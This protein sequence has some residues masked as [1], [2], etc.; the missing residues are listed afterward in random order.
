[1]TFFKN[2]PS[3]SLPK[4]KS[5]QSISTKLPLQLPHLRLH[6]AV[7]YPKGGP[8]KGTIKIFPNKILQSLFIKVV[9]SPKTEFP[10]TAAIIHFKYLIRVTLRRIQKPLG[11]SPHF[12]SLNI[13]FLVKGTKK[14]SF[15]SF[16]Q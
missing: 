12:V 10:V 5:S 11:E 13:P 7:K 15:I 2:L 16:I 9:A 14:V 6:I 3:N 1:M 4:G 8:K